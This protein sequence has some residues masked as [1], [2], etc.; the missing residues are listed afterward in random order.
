MPARKGGGDATVHLLGERRTEIVGAQAGLDVAD[1]DARIE[2]S[3]RGAEH[4][5][6]VTLHEDSRRLRF[7]EPSGDA[8]EHPRREFGQRLAGRHQAEIDVGLQSERT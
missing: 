8:S 7:S 1:G 5:G 2:G 4:G 6:G 3:H